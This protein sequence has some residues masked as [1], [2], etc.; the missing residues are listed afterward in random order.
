MIRSTT[1]HPSAITQVV[2]IGVL[3]ND[4]RSVCRAGKL[5]HGVAYV[6]EAYRTLGSRGSAMTRSL[7]P[8]CPAAGKDM[9]TR[10]GPRDMTSGRGCA[11]APLWCW[12]RRARTLEVPS[13]AGACEDERPVEGARGVPTS[14]GRS[15]TSTVVTP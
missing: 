14:T 1:V 15:T 6:S 7:L 2:E 12:H 10:P 3:S 4:R 9:G 5:A 13:E 8:R 11:A